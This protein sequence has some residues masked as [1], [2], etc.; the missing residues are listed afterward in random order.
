M[1]LY[2]KSDY[3]VQRE[4]TMVPTDTMVIIDIEVMNFFIQCRSDKW[5][6][7]KVLI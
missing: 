4:M 6:F 2:G 3:P 5:M 7:G 1:D